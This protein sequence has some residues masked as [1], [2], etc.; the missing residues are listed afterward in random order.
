MITKKNERVHGLE[1]MLAISGQ[2]R[3]SNKSSFM[4]V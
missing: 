4:D 3:D 1:T 2:L